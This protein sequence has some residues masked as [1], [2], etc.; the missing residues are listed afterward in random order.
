MLLTVIQAQEVQERHYFLENLNH[1]A[2]FW[3]IR[4]VGAAL[5]AFFII[6]YFNS[7][8]R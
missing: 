5:L 4:I 8:K 2:V 6:S 7:K 3:G 1:P